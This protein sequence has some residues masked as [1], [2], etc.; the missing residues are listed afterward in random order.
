MKNSF[1]VLTFL[2]FGLVICSAQNPLEQRVSIKVKN[3]S[4]ETALYMLINESGAKLTFT[5]KLL[6]V[7][8]VS[9]KFRDQPL[10]DVLKVLLGGTSIGFKVIGKQVVLYKLAIS[11]ANLSFTINGFWRMPRLASG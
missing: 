11:D 7:K 10:K 2:L 3:V 8:Q 9:L 1:L 6:P 4:L 5:N